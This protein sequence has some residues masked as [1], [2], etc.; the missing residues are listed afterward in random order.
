L[1]GG[2][3]TIDSAE[4]LIGF[5]DERNRATLKFIERFVL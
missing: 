1:V 2:F 5:S 4:K 3:L